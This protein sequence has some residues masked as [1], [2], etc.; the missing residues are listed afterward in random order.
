VDFTKNLVGKNAA[1]VQ[2]VNFNKHSRVPT[3][4]IK[5]CEF[6]LY[7]TFMLNTDSRPNI[8]KENFISRDITV[9]HNNILK[10]NGINE[11]PVYSWRNT[12]LLF[13]NKVIFHCIKRFSNHTIRHIR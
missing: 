5:L 10:L 11:Y 6:T 9:D 4:Q 7:I 1:E 2:S 13:E 12:L 8:I 3:I